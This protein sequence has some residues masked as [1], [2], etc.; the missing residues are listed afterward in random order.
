[1]G[2]SIVTDSV[3]YS[4]CTVISLVPSMHSLLL[5]PRIWGYGE[6]S[7]QYYFNINMDTREQ[8]LYTYIPY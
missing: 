5:E 2:Q 4:C 3:C 1:M 6:I 7:A 8:G